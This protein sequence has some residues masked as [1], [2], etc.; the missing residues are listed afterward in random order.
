MNAFS[1]QNFEDGKILLF[2]KEIGWT[3]FD[4]V[5][6]VKNLIR[7]AYQI[8]KIK[9]GHAGTLDPLASGLLIICTGKLTKKISD[10]QSQKKIYTGKITLGS[11]TPSYDLET[12]IDQT[13]STAH[14]NEELI[15]K[16][17]LHFL[18][19]KTQVPPIFSA[20]RINGRRA[21]DYARNN[22]S[23]ELKPN[24]IKI[25]EL[26]LELVDQNQLKFDV[27]CSKGT[28]IR[29]LARDI[30]EALKSGAHLSKLRRTKSGDFMIKDAKS[31]EEWIQIINT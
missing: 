7:Q 11:T 5:K 27:K 21:Y 24:E 30:G 15:E 9:V 26:K 31:V 1:K 3:S 20:K 23:I 18:N 29:S 2:N 22:E 28:Y 8:K 12:S 19:A 13:F 14:I 16:I 6:K 25:H 10:I 17:R 4:V